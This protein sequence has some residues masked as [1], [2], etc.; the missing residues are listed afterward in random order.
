MSA[1]AGRGTMLRLL[2]VD[3][4]KNIRSHLATYLLC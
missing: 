1:E 2:V 3:D 4:D